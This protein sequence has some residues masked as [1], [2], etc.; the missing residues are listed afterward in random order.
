MQEITIGKNEAKQNEK[1]TTKTIEGN[2]NK[3]DKINVE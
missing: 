2:I 1:G 3:T